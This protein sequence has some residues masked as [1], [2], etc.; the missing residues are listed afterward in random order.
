MLVFC[1]IYPRVVVIRWKFWN[2]SLGKEGEDQLGQSLEKWRH[3]TWHLGGKE[4]LNATKRRKANWIGHILRRNYLLKHVAEVNID[5][6]GRRR[7]R[8][9][10]LLDGLKETWRYWKLE[11]DALV[12]TLWKLAL[13][14]AMDLTWDRLRDD[15]DDDDDDESGSIRFLSSRR[16]F[17]IWH[18]VPLFFLKKG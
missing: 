13:E 18:F 7:R 12:S 5:V 3:F 15:D 8:R 2:V 9:K 11:E 16:P 1:S 10:Q 17:N 4:H 14:G 6:T